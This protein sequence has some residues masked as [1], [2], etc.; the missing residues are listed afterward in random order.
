[1]HTIKGVKKGQGVK[2]A[3]KLDM[4]KPYDRMEAL[5]LDTSLYNMG[6]GKVVLYLITFSSCVLRGSLVYC[7]MQKEEMIWLGLKW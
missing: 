5:L 3:L 2:V 1:M 4:T 7:V 6:Y